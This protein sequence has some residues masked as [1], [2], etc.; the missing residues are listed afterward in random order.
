MAIILWA[1]TS[2]TALP[3][4]FAW[5]MAGSRKAAREQTEG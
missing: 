4:L 2:V 5:A 1:A 3:A